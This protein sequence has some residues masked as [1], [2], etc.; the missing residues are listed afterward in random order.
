MGT[1]KKKSNIPKKP[2]K[3]QKKPQGMLSVFVT[4]AIAVLVAISVVCGVVFA[5]TGNLPFLS[6]DKVKSRYIQEITMDKALDIFESEDD[7]LIYFGYEQCPYC[8]H[9]KPVLKEVAEETHTKVYYVKTRD[10]DKNLTYTEAQR[11]SLENFIG[12]FMDENEDEDNKLWLYVP[13]LVYSDQGVVTKGY[14]GTGSDT[15]D[16]T[17]KQAKALKKQYEKIF[18]EAG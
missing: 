5:V 15:S 9:A 11:E 2:K 4:S 18:A 14:E 10:K 16:M 3:P 7:A 8:Q 17:K 1:V 12:D 13:L 6:G